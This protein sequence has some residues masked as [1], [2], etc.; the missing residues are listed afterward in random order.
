[1]HGCARSLSLLRLALPAIG[2]VLAVAG[3]ADPQRRFHQNDRVFVRQREQFVRI[4]EPHV[5]LRRARSSF[6]SDQ[7]RAAADELERA[8]AGFA[9][10]AERAAGQE[11]KELERA[12]R[13]LAKL[14][15]DV[16]ARRVGEI[17]NLDRALA[18]A[19]RTLA[20]GPAPEAPAKAPEAK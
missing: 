1:M 3:S 9:Y 12:E 11:R 2:V 13:G 20:Q 4:E 17:T 7:M 14:A 19:E 16:R 6:S 15:D 5:H 10:F 8:A 18:E